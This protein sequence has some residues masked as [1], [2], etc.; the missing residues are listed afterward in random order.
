V[1]KPPPTARAPA[2]VPTPTLP[3]PAGLV[4]FSSGQESCGVNE[5]SR[6]LAQAMRLAGAVVTEAKL[7]NVALLGSAPAGAE[8]LVHAEPSLLRQDIYPALEA[9]RLRGAK[10]VV[11]FHHC[12]A[13][14]S[15]ASSGSPTS[16]GA[17]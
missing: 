9:A 13:C 7:S 6:G 11:C 3:F 1:V 16:C 12:D 8:V 17:P 5:Y 14:S 2:P 15:R 10:V 4:S